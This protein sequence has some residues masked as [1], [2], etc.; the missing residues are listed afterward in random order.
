MH[1]TFS[2]IPWILTLKVLIPNSLIFWYCYISTLFQCRYVFVLFL[3]CF[4]ARN[5]QCFG[6]FTSQVQRRFLYAS[7][8]TFDPL[9]LSS[10]YRI[11]KI[12]RSHWL[13]ERSVCI[14]AITKSFRFFSGKLFYKSNRKLFS[15]VCIA[16][17]K[18]SR[19]YENSR[20]LCK[21]S[22]WSRVSSNS[23]NPS[24]VYITLCKHRKRFLLLKYY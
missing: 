3:F 15:G 19:G 13:A 24:R 10:I 1:F 5:P 20:Q 8:L 16:W 17:H 9:W 18:H 4:F 22:T 23:P 21:P 14:S 2:S 12:V 7:S 11:T 6:S